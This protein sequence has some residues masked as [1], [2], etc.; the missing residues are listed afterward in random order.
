MKL[1]P[2]PD[3]RQRKDHDCG[4]A[5]FRCIAEY[6]GI[7]RRR[8]PLADP[9]HGTHPDALEPAFRRAG[10][11]VLSGEMDI[12][13]LRQLTGYGWPVACLVKTAGGDG[14]WVAVRGVRYGVVYCMDPL[15]GDAKLP[16]AEWE[17]RWHDYDRR[18]TVFRRF[19]LAVWSE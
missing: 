9:L 14:H 8:P 11:R 16:Q 3:V 18:G 13:A 5:V 10:F 4:A 19:G 12:G 1:L 15:T 2:L 17:S 7:V 6:W